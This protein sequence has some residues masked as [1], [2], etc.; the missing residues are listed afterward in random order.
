MSGDSYSILQKYEKQIKSL[1]EKERQLYRE[2]NGIEKESIAIKK[3]ISNFT[4]QENQA[5]N[6]LTWLGFKELLET[7]IVSVDILISELT[8]EYDELKTGVNYVTMKH[9]YEI[10]TGY[11]ICLLQEYLETKRR[12]SYS[13]VKSIKKRKTSLWTHSK[14]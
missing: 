4:A 13:L 9:T 5:T 3:D 7:A 1:D 8:K 10:I 6:D 14:K 12:L 11:G 2:I